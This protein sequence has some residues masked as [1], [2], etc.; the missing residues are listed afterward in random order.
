MDKTHLERREEILKVM[1]QIME[2]LTKVDD[3]R[4]EKSKKK[5]KKKK[6]KDHSYTEELNWKLWLL[7]GWELRRSKDEKVIKQRQQLSV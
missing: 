4:K 6:K 5:K 7:F 3:N 2:F 1:G